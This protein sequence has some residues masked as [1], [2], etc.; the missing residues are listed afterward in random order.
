MAEGVGPPRGACHPRKVGA[1]SIKQDRQRTCSPVF[2][3]CA[4]VLTLLWSGGIMGSR[5]IEM[6]RSKIDDPWKHSLEEL[7]ISFGS[8]GPFVRI[9]GKVLFQGEV[10]DV[11]GSSLWVRPRSFSP[12]KGFGFSGEGTWEIVVPDLSSRD[13]H[14]Q[15]GDVVTFFGGLVQTYPNRFDMTKDTII[16]NVPVWEPRSPISAIHMFS[17][18]FCGWSQALEAICRFEPFHDVAQQF[19]VD[20]DPRTMQNWANQFEKPVHFGSTAPEHPWCPSSHVGLCAPVNDC[21][22]C[23]QI[24]VRSNLVGTA[25]PPCVTWSKGGKAQG[26]NSSA[27]YSFI[28]AVVL[29]V[30]LQP[31]LQVY[32]CAD[33]IVKHPHFGLVSHLLKLCGFRR[34]WQQVVEYHP[35]SHNM[36][37]RWVSAWARLDMNPASIVEQFQLKAL[38]VCQWSSSLY[39]FPLP[40]DVRESL[41]LSE[42]LQRLYGNRGLLPPAKKARVASDAVIDS[43][44]RERV[45]NPMDPLPTIC[46]SYG[47][48]HELASHHVAQRGLFA[49]FS[50]GPDGFQWIEPTRIVALLGG[51]TR[52]SVEYQPV[53]AYHVL[54]N[55][56]AVPQAALA[57]LVGL[58]AIHV[59]TIPILQ[60]VHDIW[61]S[62]LTSHNALVQIEG[63]FLTISKAAFA[64]ERI[65][66]RSPMG[67][68]SAMKCVITNCQGAHGIEGSCDP[69][70]S[71][72][73]LLRSCIELDQYALTQVTL[74]HGMVVASRV[75]QISDLVIISKKWEVYA[76]SV[77]VAHISFD[78]G[79]KPDASDISPTQLYVPS[80]VI[81]TIEIPTT[82]GDMITQS[83]AFVRVH[84][85]FA[86]ALGA[87]I[88]DG[89]GP[90]DPVVLVWTEPATSIL[91][92]VYDQRNLESV[93][94]FLRERGF[95]EWS[96]KCLSGHSV[97]F[98]GHEWWVF[99]PAIPEDAIVV[100]ENLS[101]H[102]EFHVRPLRGLVDHTTRVVIQ[103]EDFMIQRVNGHS[104]EFPRIH[105]CEDGDILSVVHRD[106]DLCALINSGHVYAGGHPQA[107]DEVWHLR[108]GA[109]FSERCHFCNSTEGCCASDELQYAMDW[110]LKLHPQHCSVFAIL[111]WDGVETEFDESHFHFP[112]VPIEATTWLAVLIKCHWVG[113]EITRSGD[114]VCLTILGIDAATAYVLASILCRRLDITMKKMHLFVDLFHQAQYACG[115]AL[116]FRWYERYGRHD[117][118]QSF[119]EDLE[120]LPSWRYTLVHEVLNRSIENW[121][122]HDTPPHLWHFA[123]QLRLDFFYHLGLQANEAAP[124]IEYDF[125]L[126][127]PPTITQRPVGS[128]LHFGQYD[129]LLNDIKNQR[130]DEMLRYPGWMGSDIADNLLQILRLRCPNVAFTAPARWSSANRTICTFGGYSDQCQYHAHVF[131]LVLWD[132]HWVMCEIQRISGQCLMW[133]SAP[134]SY[135]YE[136]HHMTT[137]LLKLIGIEDDKTQV[138]LLPSEPPLGLCGW[139]LLHDLFAKCQV[140]LPGPGASVLQAIAANPSEE[141]LFEAINQANEVWATIAP[142]HIHKFAQDALAWFVH[143]MLRG[144]ITPAF[145]SGGAVQSTAQASSGPVAMA[146]DTSVDVLQIRD[147]GAKKSSSVQSKWED[148]RMD[149][150]HPFRLEDKTVVPQVH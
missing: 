137:Q 97:R 119:E 133:I 24:R 1:S 38:Q 121:Q 69:T 108:Q 70:W 44:L 61:S 123:H 30:I 68:S 33:E 84:R 31:N 101:K 96:L 87:H 74:R 76:A 65:P 34:I 56:I 54:G 130:I 148:L 62:R 16:A 83:E 42:E 86:E 115:W 126:R 49:F 112:E 103:G 59:E 63:I 110:L 8:A 98:P 102:V 55:A 67:E 58:Q 29:T 99:L 135:G 47:H 117:S 57:I 66:F 18:S 60:I 40:Q 132:Q 17:G 105:E 150:D 14:F 107:E 32:E 4:V 143:D 85:F 129:A 124:V 82:A 93:R 51:Q 43:V 35:M 37:S 139:L 72:H 39:D 141:R 27:G 100:I 52:V 144:R 53:D 77:K 88:F 10:R 145:A 118:L 146:V 104:L 106:R 75:E 73:D 9:A 142:P 13:W 109:N 36:R 92:R 7:F 111:L 134:S 5:L 95:H 128:V 11:S 114:S 78:E 116:L 15:Q 46:A 28:E 25:S 136:L 125:I 21:S 3:E 50:S 20:S 120:D 79:E 80:A 140:A 127:I 64:F 122:A 23:H 71:V 90:S 81:E 138:M 113:C 6:I 12:G 89:E 22:L 26:L 131:S 41:L 19:Y 48:Q 45:V 94:E 147:P 91:A 149:K 2:V